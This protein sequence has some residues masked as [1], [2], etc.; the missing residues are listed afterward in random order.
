VAATLLLGFLWFRLDGVA[1]LLAVRAARAS[2]TS[3]AEDT[4]T[5]IARE[6]T[7]SRQRETALLRLAQLQ[8]ARGSSK[9]A[10]GWLEL[11][12]SDYPADSTNPERRYWVSRALFGSGDTTKA[13]ATV[14]T[15]RS[16]T[17][18]SLAT[19]FEA[20]GKECAAF[21]LRV[22]ALAADSTRSA[23][24]VRPDSAS[25]QPTGSPNPPEA[26]P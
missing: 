1:E 17:S 14:R 12:A 6:H 8:I 10:L 9:E 15:V 13:C 7:K 24:R 23:E 16:A 2:S 19:D 25:V 18:R 20:M 4:Y 22:Q 3:E 21:Q 26:A 11:L 5:R